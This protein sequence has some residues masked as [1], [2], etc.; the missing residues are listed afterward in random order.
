M[1]KKEFEEFSKKKARL[2]Q[3]KNELE[4]STKVQLHQDYIAWPASE[5]ELLAQAWIAYY[6]KVRGTR[7][8]ERFTAQKAAIR[9]NDMTTVKDLALEA[10]NEILNPNTPRVVKPTPYDPDIIAS[11]SEVQMY[12]TSK[13]ELEKM[14][15]EEK[16]SW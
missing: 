10:R 7:A 1:T 12:V 2:T 4:N 5:R 16:Q 15:R 14:E 11:S 9:V 3:L 13:L 8:Y 6:D